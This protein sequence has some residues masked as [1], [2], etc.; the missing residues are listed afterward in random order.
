MKG[1]TFFAE[2]TEPQIYGIKDYGLWIK[3][4]DGLRDIKRW[5]SL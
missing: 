5:L 4:L 1:G 3:K 2:I